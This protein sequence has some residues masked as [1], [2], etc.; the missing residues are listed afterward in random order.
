MMFDM[1]IKLEIIISIPGVNVYTAIFIVKLLSFIYVEAWPTNRIRPYMS[2][3]E[4]AD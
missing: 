4:I 2:H 1:N 3:C